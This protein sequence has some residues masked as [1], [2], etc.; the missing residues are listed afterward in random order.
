TNRKDV[1]LATVFGF[2]GVLCLLMLVT[3]L[4]YG[5]MPQAELGALR[6]PSMAGVLES[7]VGRWGMIFISVGLIISVL[8]A[9]LS[10]SLLAAEVIYSAALKKSMPA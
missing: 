5:V 3:M 10:W 9:Y 7:I 1:G 6:Q 8:G 4:S 2:I